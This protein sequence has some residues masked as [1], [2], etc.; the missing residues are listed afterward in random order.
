MMISSFYKKYSKQ[1][2]WGVFCTLP[3]LTFLAEL[4]PSNND[5]ETWLPSDSDV[6][7]VYDRFKAEFGAEEVIL[8]ALQDGLNQPLLV[9][10]TAGR[11]ETLPT[12]RQCWTP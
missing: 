6:R 4:L 5:I 3:I 7:I 11:I 8:V 12:V 9:E 1:L 10:S 2:I